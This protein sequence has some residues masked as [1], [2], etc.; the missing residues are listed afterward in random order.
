MTYQ[1]RVIQLTKNACD[2]LVRAAKAMPED[3]LSWKVL[4][5]GRSPIDLLQEVSQ[6]LRYV[7]P[8]LNDRKVE[9]DPAKFETIRAERQSWDSIEKCE[10]V[11]AKNFELFAE[12]VRN[13]PEADLDET[14]RL[15]F[16]GG[17]DSPYYE[18]MMYGY[19]NAVYHLGQTNFIQTLYGNWE[20]R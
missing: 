19:W 20:M 13:F 7:I 12:A 8:M 2:G 10:E 6:S 5:A 16:A 4:D 17:F 9:F 3:K 18:I 1:E 14:L 15:P 11:L